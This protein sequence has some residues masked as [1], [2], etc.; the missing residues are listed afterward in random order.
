M[1]HLDESL[2][3]ANQKHE[4]QS[5]HI[6][7]TLFCRCTTLLCLLPGIASVQ[8][9]WAKTVFLS[10]TGVFSLFFIHL[11]GPCRITY[12]APLEMLLGEWGC[13][14]RAT[15]VPH[16]TKLHWYIFQNSWKRLKVIELVDFTIT[17]WRRKFSRLLV[18][19]PIGS[20]E[21]RSTV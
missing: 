5:D 12:W 6:Y 4:H 14:D 17:F 10:Q 13:E 18:I 20:Q 1:N 3:W 21:Y 15:Q 8:L 16:C 11:I 7:Y 2:W 19:V 9:C